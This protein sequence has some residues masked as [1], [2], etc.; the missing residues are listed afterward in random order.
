M[1]IKSKDKIIAVSKTGLKKI[2]RPTLRSTAVASVNSMQQ[3]SNR[4]GR[5]KLSLKEINLAIAT[6][7]RG[8]KAR[9]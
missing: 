4:A 7:R 1:V 8:N 9:I 6:V 3:Q 2:V 5:D